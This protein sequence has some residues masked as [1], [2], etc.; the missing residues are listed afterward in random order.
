MSLMTGWLCP[1]GTEQL[2]NFNGRRA[3][4]EWYCANPHRMLVVRLTDVAAPTEPL[5]LL[6]TGI[7]KMELKPKWV[8][9]QLHCSRV[10]EDTLLIE[11]KQG[12]FR[13][14]CYA[15]RVF[16]DEEFKQWLGSDQMLA[17]P[18]APEFQAV[19]K[20]SVET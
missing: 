7:S 11:D 19:L 12:A 9:Q 10:N 17:N 1:N 4:V 8:I 6:C 3:D 5:F 14:T 2:E 16:G 20:R 13:V 18:S 15:L